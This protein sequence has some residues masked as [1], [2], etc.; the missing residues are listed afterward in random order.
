MTVQLLAGIIIGLP[1]GIIIGANL[2][3][4]MVGGIK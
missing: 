4:W 1:I 3:F 2:A